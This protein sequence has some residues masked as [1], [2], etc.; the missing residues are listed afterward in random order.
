MKYKFVFHLKRIL[1]QNHLRYLFDVE[2]SVRFIASNLLAN[3]LMRS[4]FRFLV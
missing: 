4:L 2:G 1:F 3:A